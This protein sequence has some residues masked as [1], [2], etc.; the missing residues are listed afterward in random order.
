MTRAN[1]R[2]TLL[3]RFTNYR[4]TRRVAPA[5]EGESAGEESE[6]KAAKVASDG[7]WDIKTFSNGK[8]AFVESK[9]DDIVTLRDDIVTKTGLR[10]IT[11]YQK[12]VKTLWDGEKDRDYWDSQIHRDDKKIEK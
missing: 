4:R 11:A 7:L 5:D 8:S 1:A 10:P 2:S 12:A 6:L 3:K 9:Q